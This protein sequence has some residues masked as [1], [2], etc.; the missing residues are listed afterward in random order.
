MNYKEQARRIVEQKNAAPEDDFDGFSPEEMSIII[1]SPLSNECPVHIRSQIDRTLLDQ[2]PVF[3]IAIHVLKAIKDNQ[4]IKL[5]STANLPPQLVK[6]IYAKKYIA[7]GII[8]AG[9][10]KLNQETKW[11]ILHSTK[12]VLKLAKLIRTYKGGLLFTAQ[13]KKL[14]LNHDYSELFLTF[15][16]TFTT[17]F[18]WAY[19]EAYEDEE[20]GQVGFLFLLYLINKYGIEFRELSFYF[21][22]YFKAFPVFKM[23][24]KSW[25][26]GS[27]SSVLAIRFFE[28]FAKWFGLVEIQRKRDG[29]TQ[30]RR[31]R[32]TRLLSHLL[33]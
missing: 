12:I 8:D 31:V 3:Q 28:R 33:S 27:S 13:T 20:I 7:D 10:T 2:S 25:F 23:R 4:G 15:F 29:L 11:D 6:E 26:A 1:Y 32:K 30:A 14:L 17:Q 24:E 16:N 9:I 21:E 22:L 5:T 19:N 18:N